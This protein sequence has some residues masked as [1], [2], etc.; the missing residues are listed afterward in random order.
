M[1]IRSRTGKPR[2]STKRTVQTESSALVLGMDVGATTS[3]AVI[4]DP[5]GRVAGRGT[6]GGGN[7]NSHPLEQAVGEIVA[8]ARAALDGIDPS[9]VQAGVLG[10]AGITKLAEPGVARE[11]RRAWREIGTTGA[12][13]VVSDCEVAFAAG[14]PDPAG[15]VLI[16][17][18]GAIAGR[19]AERRLVATVGG[20]GWLL[21][22]EGSA[23]WVGREAVRQALRAFDR[24]ERPDELTTEV[25]AHL[26]GPAGLDDAGAIRK[27]LI[28]A[29]HAAPPIRL[30]ELAPVVT[31]AAGRGGR[32]AI[33]IVTRAAALLAETA[34]SARDPGTTAPI[35]LAGGLVAVGNPIGDTLRAELT[36]D[37]ADLR[38][39]GSGAAGAAWLA[40]VDLIGPDAV[41]LHGA[42]LRPR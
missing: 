35:V 5:R 1:Y 21:G 9:R 8:A 19:I 37:D 6:A 28:N 34:R 25:C 29:V 16:A 11:F 12:V 30:A 41:G 40:A 31:S 7:P 14:S 15:T 36:A 27:K 38:T 23:F 10:M 33:E 39:A 32:A 22:D 2:K 24:G 18:T 4:C 13:R 26:L 42:Y 20:H 3:R 17:G